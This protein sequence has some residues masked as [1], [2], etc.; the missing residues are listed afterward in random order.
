[1]DEQARSMAKKPLEM[2]RPLLVGVSGTHS[3]GKTTLA[4]ALLNALQRNGLSCMLVTNLVRDLSAR[5]Y[6]IGKSADVCLNLALLS[7]FVEHILHGYEL[8]VLILDR[9]QADLWAYAGL[10]PAV[11]E[12]YLRLLETLA[13]VPAIAP[14]LVIYLPIEFCMASDNARP[15]DERY[16]LDVDRRIQ[17]AFRRFSWCPVTLRGSIQQRFDNAYALINEHL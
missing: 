14:E 15:D 16:R 13:R 12:E 6:S 4:R 5:G 3:T 9:T 11:P 17:E 10:S 1:M 8:D 2:R 7:A